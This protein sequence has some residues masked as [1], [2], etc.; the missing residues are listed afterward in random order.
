MAGPRACGLHGYSEECDVILTVDVAG[1]PQSPV[2]TRVL[3]PSAAD[4]SELET[5]LC[6]RAVPPS[7]ATHS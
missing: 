4:G 6:Q 5:A 3:I 2:R 1:H 7:G